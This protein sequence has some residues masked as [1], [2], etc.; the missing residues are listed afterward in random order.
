[1][2][3][4]LDHFTNVT[5]VSPASFTRSPTGKVRYTLPSCVIQNQVP[6]EFTRSVVVLLLATLDLIL[7]PDPSCSDFILT[8]PSHHASPVLSTSRSQL[9]LSLSLRSRIE[10]TFL[11]SCLRVNSMKLP[12]YL[13]ALLMK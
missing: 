3:S 11:F 1:M 10:F 7:I 5:H 13:L 2:M 9:L 4:L 8:S 12:S 6:I